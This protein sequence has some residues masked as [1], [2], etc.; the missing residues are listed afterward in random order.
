MKKIKV[1][2][3]ECSLWDKGDIATL[4]ES[5][6][7]RHGCVMDGE[8]HLHFHNSLGTSWYDKIS[9]GDLVTDGSGDIDTHAQFSHDAGKV[10]DEDLK[11]SMPLGVLESIDYR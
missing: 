2:C 10:S 9:L 7:E 4:Y 11:F 1:G 5:A 8:D 3:I 6:D